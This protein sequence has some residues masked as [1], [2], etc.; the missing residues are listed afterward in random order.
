ME[1]VGGLQAAL[2]LRKFVS[3]DAVKLPVVIPEFPC[4]RLEIIYSTMKYGMYHV[5][6][7]SLYFLLATSSYL[8]GNLRRRLYSTDSHKLHLSG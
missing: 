1:K 8:G 2:S 6:R 5:I 4:H 7:A 3:Q